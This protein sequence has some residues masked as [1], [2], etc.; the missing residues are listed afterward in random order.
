MI[1]QEVEAALNDRF[2][3]TYRIIPDDRAREE[4]ISFIRGWKT[5]GKDG[6][7]VSDVVSALRLPAE[8]VEEI[9]EAFERQGKL[10]G[11]L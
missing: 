5:S 4:I 7:S 2:S 6:F 10:K 11:N 1:R 9:L 8:Q 3:P